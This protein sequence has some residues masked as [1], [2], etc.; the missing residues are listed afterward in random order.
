MRR[1]EN[2]RRRRELRKPFG[3]FDAKSIE[4]FDK[5]IE[6]FDRLICIF[7]ELVELFDD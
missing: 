4:I 6:Q 5:L 7:D 2:E 3:K 1:E